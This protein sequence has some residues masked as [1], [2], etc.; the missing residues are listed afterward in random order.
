MNQT[1]ILNQISHLK[2]IS[3]QEDKLYS[4]LKTYIDIFPVED[5]FLYRYSPI[6]YLCEGVIGLSSSRII[7]IREERASIKTSPGFI[8]LLKE[9]KARFYSGIDLIKLMTSDYIFPS[10]INSVLVVPL[11]IGEV[12]IGFILSYHFEGEPNFD[13]KLLNTI[14]HFAKFSGGL[15]DNNEMVGNTE[16]L[17]KREVEVMQ[18]IS[19]GENTKEIASFLGI[20]NLTVQQYVKSVLKKLTVQNRTH[21]IAVLLRKGIIG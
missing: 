19:C 4:I 1:E 10:T 16:S 2:N 7:Y 18:R 17:S 15:L 13:K 3:N 11:C 9:K 12:I 5:A 20:S 6:G 21:A 8:P 14:T